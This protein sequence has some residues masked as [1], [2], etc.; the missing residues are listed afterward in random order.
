M[1]IVYHALDEHL[2][3][4]VAIKTLPP[5]L[6]ADPQ[7]RVRFLREARTA[8]G[9]SHPNI[10]PIYSAAEREGVVYFVMGFVNGA[11]LAEHIASRG[12]LRPRE[13]V[14]L[15]S[16]LADALGFAH[17]HGVVHRDVKAE[18]VLLDGRTGRAM[19]TDFGIARVTETKPLTATGT[20]LGT[21]HYMSPEQVSGDVIDGRSDLYSL[22]VLAF[23]ALS[24]RFPFERSTASAV[25]VAHV[26]S[27]PPRMREVWPECP[28][29]LEHII[30]RLL[31]KAPGDRYADARELRT[32]LVE[33]ASE[34]VDT[35]DT[36]V[37]LEHAEP[38]AMRMSSADAQQV[39]SR[40]AELQANTGMITPPPSFTRRSNQELVTQGYDAALVKASAIDAGI[41]EKY[42][43][44]AFVERAAA[45]PVL[46]ERGE[47]MTR[48]PNIFV[49]A[50]TK[51]EYTTAFDGELDDDAFEEVADEV[52]AAL[53]EMVT[54]SAVGRTLTIT[55]GLPSSR[56]GGMPRYVQV[57]ISSRNGRTQLRAFEDLSQLAAGWF[58]GLGAGGGIGGAMLA[59]GVVGSASHS[60][61]LALAAVVVTAGSALWLTRFIF[62]QSARDKGQQLESLL[63]R[64]VER[65]RQS[66]LKR[67]AQQQLSKR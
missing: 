53:G 13:V 39:W 56:T 43:E 10:V 67:N 14:T 42:V 23:F 61:L 28:P 24:G 45:E 16:E 50:S 46:I 8:A 55:T 65:A 31:A 60:P 4:E 59:G 64:I 25:V 12:R 26:N 30:A 54:V 15:L 18:N 47:V 7:V 27:V 9:L 19:V 32:A 34:I 44:R 41:D 17:A 6:A 52:R 48:R 51:L 40:A 33:A 62:A 35:P 11:S 58:G 2:H 3:R 57:H 38:S 36:V 29:I 20:V 66:M 49:G 21:V 37:P 1:G 63:R 5:H 22:G